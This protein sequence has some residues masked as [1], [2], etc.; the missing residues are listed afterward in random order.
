MVSDGDVVRLQLTCCNSR[1]IALPSLSITSSTLALVRGDPPLTEKEL[2]RLFVT[3]GLVMLAISMIVGP[4][5]HD[6]DAYV[7]QWRRMLDGTNPWVDVSRASGNSYGPVHTILAPLVRISPLAPKFVMNLSLIAAF[8]VLFL[9]ILKCC[10]EDRD[11]LK[12]F[13]LAGPGNI[14]MLLMGLPYGNNDG[15]TAS[16]VL[17]AVIARA[18]RRFILAGTLLGIAGGL[19]F[20]PLLLVPFFMMDGEK[21]RF[22]LGLA[23]AA[24]FAAIMA[25]AVFY[26][27]SAVLDPLLFASDRA[28][29]ILSIIPALSSHPWLIGGPESVA[30]LIDYNSLF[31]LAALGIVFI[32]CWR[33]GA[34]WLE[35]S[36]IGLM[37]ALTAYKVGHQQFYLSWLVL[38]AALTLIGSQTADRVA[39]AALPFALFLSGLQ[40]FYSLT[41]HLNWRF[42]FFRDYLGFVAFPLALWTLTLL[43]RA[44]ASPQRK[45]IGFAG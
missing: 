45:S 20:F 8:G 31:I 34:D 1:S 17:F 23:A 15:W 11:A 42:T 35:A 10:A 3:W 19:K 29:K 9:R 43:F 39:K 4:I 18:D 30:I 32:A 22:R 21:F 27:G 6:Y 41:L 28:P 37:T 5:V 24:T 44:T 7:D 2:W 40:L 36:I 33:M 38:V 14:L 25:A 16:F 13:V 12:L 26:W